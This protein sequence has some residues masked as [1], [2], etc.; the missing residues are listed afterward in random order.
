M[1]V[2]QAATKSPWASRLVLAIG[3]GTALTV[4][5]ERRLTIRQDGY[6]NNAMQPNRPPARRTG[7]TRY[8]DRE[9]GVGDETVAL[10][11]K[12][13]ERKKFIVGI[14]RMAGIVLRSQKH[15]KSEKRGDGRGRVKASV[16]AG[17]KTTRRPCG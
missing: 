17:K 3:L 13:I 16:A 4:G 15:A 6:I 11:R 7:G 5:C 1:H 2:L 10:P 12:K 9:N 14:V 8:S